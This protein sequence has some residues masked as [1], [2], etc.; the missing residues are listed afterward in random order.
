MWSQLSKMGGESATHVAIEVI[1]VVIIIRCSHVRSLAYRSTVAFVNEPT[2]ACE[3][4]ISYT[5]FVI[6]AQRCRFRLFIW[7]GMPQF[8]GKYISEV[9]LKAVTQSHREI[10]KSDNSTLCSF[11]LRLSLFLRSSPIS[12]EDYFTGGY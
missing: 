6:D 7:H 4:F 10:V 11:S 12:R 3:T 2:C 5:E 8:Y 1:F 9:G